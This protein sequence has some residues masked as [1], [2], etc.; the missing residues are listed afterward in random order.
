M[1]STPLPSRYRPRGGLRSECS[2]SPTASR[3]SVRRCAWRPDDLERAP[4]RRGIRSAVFFP[5]RETGGGHHSV[6]RWCGKRDQRC[7]FGLVSIV[8]SISS[9]GHRCAPVQAYCS[10]P[11]SEHLLT[12]GVGAASAWTGRGVPAATA[13]TA[14]TA[15]PAAT[16]RRLP[17][18]GFVRSFSMPMMLLN[19]LIVVLLPSIS[20][21]DP[22]RLWMAPAADGGDV[23]E[24]LQI[25]TPVSG[26]WMVS[27]RVLAGSSHDWSPSPRSI[28]APEK[29]P[30]SRTA[31][32]LTI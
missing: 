19:V 15:R 12:G 4:R 14:A 26:V 8:T 3:R 20:F 17:A 28:R 13:R 11:K 25:S 32:E 18:L 22:G 29:V 27:R 31:P 10:Q 21:A 23:R 24:V 30:H 1:R 7:A 16:I 2:S 9:T 6:V 5:R